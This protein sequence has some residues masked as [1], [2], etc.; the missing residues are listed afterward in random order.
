MHEA[1]S[2]LED[3]PSTPALFDG[4]LSDR[5]LTLADCAG[6]SSS[7]TGLL[8]EAPNRMTNVPK[9]EVFPR[10]FGVFCAEK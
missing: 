3:L 10:D 4:L 5:N 8:A 7:G 1:L 6:R 9:N 2:L